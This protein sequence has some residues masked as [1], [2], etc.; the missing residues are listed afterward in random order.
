MEAIYY[1]STFN[2]VSRSIDTAVLE[3]VNVVQ[4]IFINQILEIQ[5]KE[6]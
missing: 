5:L 4:S 6:I 1:F 3:V 2:V